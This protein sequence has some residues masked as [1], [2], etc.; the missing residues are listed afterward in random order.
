MESVLLSFLYIFQ[1]SCSVDFSRG[2]NKCIWCNLSKSHIY[3]FINFTVTVTDLNFQLNFLEYRILY[4][5]LRCCVFK[6]IF[7][8]KLTLLKAYLSKKKKMVMCGFE[9]VLLKY[10]KLL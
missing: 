2:F 7:S 3:I 6:E 4:I 9:N 8:K 5:Q 1:N 10:E